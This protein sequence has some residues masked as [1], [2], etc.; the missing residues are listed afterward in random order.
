MPLQL[1]AGNIGIVLQAIDNA[2]DASRQSNLG[3]R[4]TV[5]HGVAGANL[6]RNTSLMAHIH[7]LI[8]KRNDKTVEIGSCDILQMAARNN[9]SLKGIG[10]RFQVII[11]DLAARHLHLFENMVVGAADQNTGLLDVQIAN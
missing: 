2:R 9:T 5:T 10:N 6:D 7:Q 11:H 4:N 3:I 1:F 8:Y